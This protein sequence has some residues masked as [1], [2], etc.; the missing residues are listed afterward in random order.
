MTPDAEQVSQISADLSDLRREW[1]KFHIELERLVGVGEGEP[2]Q[3]KTFQLSAEFPAIRSLGVLMRLEED[4]RRGLF[5]TLGLDDEF[6]KEVVS[7]VEGIRSNRE[8]LRALSHTLPFSFHSPALEAWA[9]YREHLRELAEQPIW[10][11]PNQASL[12]QLF[13]LPRLSYECFESKRLGVDVPRRRDEVCEPTPE[14]PVDPIQALRRLIDDDAREPQLIL[15]LGGPGLGKSCLATMLVDALSED[16][17]IQPLYIRLRRVDPQRPLLAEVRRLLVE[18]G[19]EPIA[20]DLDFVSRPVLVLDGFDELLDASRAS[21]ESF[22]YKVKDLLRE[23]GQRGLRIVLT[24]RDTLLGEKQEAPLPR[25]S[26]LLRIL[27][28]DREK[29]ARWSERWSEVHGVDFDGTRFLRAEAS[30]EEETPSS[31]ELTE[32][33]KHPLMLFMLARMESEGLALPDELEPGQGAEVFRRIVD[34]C[35]RRHEELR[36]DD[37]WKAPQMRRFLRLAGFTTVARGRQLLELEDLQEAIRAAGLEL[38]ADSEQFL[39]E[40]TILSFTFHSHD[41]QRFEFTH[42]S[43]GEYLAAEHL[44][45][46]FSRV[47]EQLEDEFGELQYRLTEEQATREWLSNFGPLVCTKEVEALLLPMLADWRGFLRGRQSS[48]DG[49]GL[50]RFRQ[51]A[52]AI[53]RTLV[54]EEQAE[55]ALRVA[56]S[57]RLRPSQVLGHSLVNIIGLAGLAWNAIGD[58]F[59]PELA[60][61]G[62]FLNAN[63]FVQLSGGCPYDLGERFTFAGISES[64]LAKP[65]FGDVVFTRAD[66]R[67]VVA[68][69]VSFAFSVALEADFTGA[70]LEKVVFFRSFLQSA[71]FDRAKMSGSILAFAHIVGAKLRWADLRDATLSQALLQNCDLRGADLRGASFYRADLS[72]ANFRDADLRGAHLQFSELFGADFTGAKLAGAKFDHAIGVTEELLARAAA[73]DEDEGE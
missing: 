17:G 64:Y 27:P 15:V 54:H 62:M 73:P 69:A 47:I 32:I 6:R 20:E 48:G 40:K 28:F 24:G 66:F 16:A 29:V 41:Q 56:R 60:A 22:L 70:S 23:E 72:G 71:V 14:L 53:Y 30:A 45:A 18:D 55:E 68:N 42:R 13:V 38:P 61:P 36:P 12:R 4:Q 25:G 39:A 58:K 46:S 7:V 9:R 8:L 19:F 35:C 43:F 31:S 44:A 10:G 3:R 5:V 49:P 67:G 52:D 26:H 2:L 50:E 57:W 1:A 33:A 59:K 63:R 65:Q 21:M 51:R 34:W 11:E 37:L